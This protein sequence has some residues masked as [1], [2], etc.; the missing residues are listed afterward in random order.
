MPRLA[1]ATLCCLAICP[2]LQAAE[3]EFLRIHFPDSDLTEADGINAR[4]VIVGSYVDTD[5]VSHGFLLRDGMYKTIDVPGAMETLA[6]RAI[7]AR[8]D[9][10]GGFLDAGSVRHG[11]L[12]SDG[13]FTQIDFPGAVGTYT[14]GINNAGDITGGYFPKG[15]GDNGTFIRRNG[16]FYDVDIPGASAPNVRAAQD[17]GR[18]LVGSALMDFDGGFHGFVRRKPGEFELIELPSLSVSCS[19]VRGINERGDMVGGF[20]YLDSIDECY[21]PE[22][23]RHGFLLRDGELKVINYPG[24]VVTDAFAINDDGVIVGHYIDKN[25]N[26]HGFKAVPSH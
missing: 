26:T 23:D 21:R 12:R 15:G 25:G 2:P 3:Y 17:N 10:V 5:G 9:I 6:V 16:K 22:H 4:G 13:K 14:T 18:V 19:G 7:N 1:T 20:A 11:F 24:A 8:G